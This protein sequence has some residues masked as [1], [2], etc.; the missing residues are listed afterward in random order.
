MHKLNGF[1]LITKYFGD[2]NFIELKLNNNIKKMNSFFNSKL[3]AKLKAVQSEANRLLLINETKLKENEQKIE[4]LKT[5]I[6]Q[7]TIQVFN[8]LSE[9][10]DKLI[11]KTDALHKDLN[12]KSSQ[13]MCEQKKTLDEIQIVETKLSSMRFSSPEQIEEIETQT[14]QL[15]TK[16]TQLKEKLNGIDCTYYFKSNESTFILGELS[17][18]N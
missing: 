18:R 8:S 12:S 14:V 4:I 2:N 17:V 6:Q 10:Q 11:E 3:L 1:L 5:E 13:L 9:Q 16:L 7:K 15:E